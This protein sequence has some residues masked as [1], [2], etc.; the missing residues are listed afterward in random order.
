MKEYMMIFLGADY[1]NANLSQEQIQE[2]MGKWFA[3][4]DKMGKAGILVGGEALAAGGKRISGKAGKDRVITDTPAI[5]SKELIGGYYTV[6]AESFDDVVKITED[7]P[8]FDLGGTVEIREVI[9]FDQ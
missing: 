9:N 5:E 7:Y 4:G 1:A 8:D 2:R 6:K 3:W